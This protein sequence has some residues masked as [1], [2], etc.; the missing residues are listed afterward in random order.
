MR[1]IEVYREAGVVLPPRIHS[2]VTAYWRRHWMGIR[3]YVP[4]SPS[5]IYERRQRPMSGTLR[6]LRGTEA[7]VRLGGGDD[8]DC[9]TLLRHIGGSFISF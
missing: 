8:D 1:R 5:V 7:A 2:T 3:V 6:L 4:R 9:I